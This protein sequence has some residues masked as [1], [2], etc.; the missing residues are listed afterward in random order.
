MSKQE[1]LEDIL[2]DLHHDVSNVR[3][4][5]WQIE[6][7]NYYEEA[8]VKLQAYCNKQNEIFIPVRGYEGLYEVSNRGNVRSIYR[9]RNTGRLLVQSINNGYPFV[10]LSNGK[11]LTRTVHRLVAEA[12][13]S[14]PDNKPTVNHKD[15]NR[16]NNSLENLE[17][18]TRSEQQI[19]AFHVLGTIPHSTGKRKYPVEYLQSLRN[20]G[21]SIRDISIKASVPY[22]TVCYYLRN[23]RIKELKEK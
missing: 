2:E 7:D 8:K 13:L 23:Y 21:M 4:E 16:S 5:D 6:I 10:T 1:S 3:G 9:G 14:N 17:W 15:G 20:L 12:F 22:P 18:A 11:S 19:H